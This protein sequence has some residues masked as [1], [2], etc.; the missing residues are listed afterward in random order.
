MFG[1]KGRREKKKRCERRRNAAEKAKP[2]SSRHVNDP[3]GANCGGGESVPRR[4]LDDDSGTTELNASA[5]SLKAAEPLRA[6]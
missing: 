5:N 1:E 6:T 4:F 2:G 3:A